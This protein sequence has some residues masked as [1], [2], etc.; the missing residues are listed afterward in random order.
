MVTI[1][2]VSLAGA[3]LDADAFRMSSAEMAKVSTATRR[4]T[5]KVY[6]RYVSL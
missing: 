5:T 1:S 2:P 3:V 6:G 4:F